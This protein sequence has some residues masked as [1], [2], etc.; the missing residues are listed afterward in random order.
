MKAGII[1]FHFA[2]NQGA[3]LQ[4]CALKTYLE[5]LG[6]DACVIDYRP[7]YHAVK[8]AAV[9]NPFVT[10]HN[11]WKK[12]FRKPLVKRVVAAAKGFARGTVDTIKGKD[13][14]M[15]AKFAAFTDK[16]LNQTR[17][18]SSLAALKKNPP[19]LDAYISG[20]DQLWNPELLDQSLDAAYFLDFGGDNVKKIT[21]AISPKESYSE[22]EKAQIKE[23]CASLDAVCIR[24][25]NPCI[26]EVLDE[27]YT[28]CI[29]PTLLLNEEDYTPLESERL[30]KEPYIFVYGFETSDAINDAVRIISEELGAKVINGSPERIK[31]TTDCKR[32]RNFSPDE[33]LSYIKHAEFVV[34]S[35][36]HG[37]AFS[38]IY[39]KQFA[40][41]PHTTRGKR[42]TELLGKLGLESRLWLENG[43][44]WQSK[45]DYTLP[46]ENLQ[47]LRDKAKGYLENNLK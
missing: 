7:S 19:Q 17:R 33:F 20:S 18:Y 39:K 14:A 30:E 5:K 13:A 16:N 2:H 35:S 32:V 47:K 21:Y 31:L 27:P 22:K 25:E 38:L 12:N 37:T 28:V 45:I 40:V 3:V 9:K 1:T 24:E 36:F 23:L 34:T 11:S 15:E 26:A 44:D 43:C 46:Y 4:C 41:V 29:D 6:H 10:A 8:Y 42:M